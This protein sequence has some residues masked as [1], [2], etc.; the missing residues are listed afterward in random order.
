MPKTPTKQITKTQLLEAGMQIMQ[1]KGYNNTGISEVLE[2]VQVPK[3]SF[4]YYFQSKE[5]FGLQIINYFDHNYSARLRVY[6]EDP[7]LS[8]LNRLRRYCQ[9]GIDSLQAQEC[10]K[11]CLLGNLSQEM[12]DQSEV[13][14]VRLAQVMSER[15]QQIA[16]C[17]QEGQSVG[18]INRAV[19][20]IELAEFFLCGWEG[21]IMRAKTL[22]ATDSQKTFMKVIFDN[23]LL[24]SK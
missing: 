4:Y 15:R 20:A 21:A 14:R 3:G 24:R 19:D 18:E 10:R 17:I 6:M 8:P 9:E 13:F 12:A 2:R 1:E 7:T 22:K 23:L 11:G 5:D 16:T